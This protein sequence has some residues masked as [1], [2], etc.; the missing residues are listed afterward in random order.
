LPPPGPMPGAMPPAEASATVR[1]DAGAPGIEEPLTTDMPSSSSLRPGFPLSQMVRIPL[2]HETMTVANAGAMVVAGNPQGAANA[3]EDWK[4]ESVVGSGMLAAV[5]PILGAEAQEAGAYARGFRRA[6]GKAVLGGGL[7]RNVPVFH[8]LATTA[9]ALADVVGDGDTQAAS[10]RFTAYKEEALLATS[11][12][13]VFHNVGKGIGTVGKGLKA[14][15][16]SIETMGARFDGLDGQQARGGGDGSGAHRD[17]RAACSEPV[18][19]ATQLDNVAQAA[20]QAESLARRSTS[21]LD[22]G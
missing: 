12:Q 8:E 3:I 22:D 9:D 19:D 15:K 21:H 14:A 18:V 4:S 17:T 11:A 16:H 5:T 1:L 10:R 20:G 13:M 2:L 6:A 7:L